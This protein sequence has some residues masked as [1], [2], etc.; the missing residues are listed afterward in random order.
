MKGENVLVNWTEDTR[1]GVR[2]I[3]PTTAPAGVMLAFSGRGHA[4]E[5]EPTPTAFLARR[6]ARAVGLAEAPIHWAKQ[7]HGNTA[8]TIR[9]AGPAAAAINVGEGDALGPDHAGPPRV[10]Q[11]ADAC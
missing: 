8:T 1:D 7:V 5:S 3:R 11:T 9:D 6:L 2:I 4:P 10:V